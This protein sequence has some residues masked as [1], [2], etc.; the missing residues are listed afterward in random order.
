MPPRKELCAAVALLVAAPAQ[1]TTVVVSEPGIVSLLGLGAIV[2]VL[3]IRYF[4]R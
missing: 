4:R 3:A 1:A 2:T